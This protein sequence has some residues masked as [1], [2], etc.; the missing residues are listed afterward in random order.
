MV[1][2]LAQEEHPEKPG[3]FAEHR[4]APL[5]LETPVLFETRSVDLGAP[6]AHY[7]RPCSAFAITGRPALSRSG[8]S[9]CSFTAPRSH[10]TTLLTI[11]VLPFYEPPAGHFDKRVDPRNP[12]SL[13][14]EAGWSGIDRTM[15]RGVE[16][17]PL[18]GFSDALSSVRAVLEEAHLSGAGYSLGAAASPQLAVEVVDV[19]LHGGHRDEEPARDLLVG[20]A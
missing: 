1:F 14:R 2:G 20:H 3:L 18:A 16:V 4:Q 9:F 6:H 11:E 12:P 8:P 15:D 5:L 7:H 19:G 10:R 17:D 13:Y